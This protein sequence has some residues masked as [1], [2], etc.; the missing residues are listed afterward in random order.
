MDIE[1]RPATVDDIPH[2]ARFLQM[3]GGGLMDAVY[4]DLIPGKSTAEIMEHRYT[5]EETSSWYR[6]YWVATYQSQVA[7]GLNLFP[8]DDPRNNWSDPLVPK[9][10]TAVYEPFKHLEAPGSLIINVTA[11]DPEF[12]GKGIARRLL[13]LARKQAKDRGFSTLSLHVFEQNEEAVKLY[14]SFG[15]EIIRRT[16]IVPHDLIRYTGDMVLMSCSA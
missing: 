13:H 16:P 4:H 1:L 7:G 3:A 8:A 6:N 12:R 10:R 15:F 9:E 2:L 14:L 11:V 5:N